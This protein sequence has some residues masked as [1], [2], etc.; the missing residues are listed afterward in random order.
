[1]PRVPWELIEHYLSV[2]PK[3]TPSNNT[4]D[5]LLTIDGTPSRRNSPNYSR[6]A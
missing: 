4:S 6:L 3:A 2:N 5:A 1:M